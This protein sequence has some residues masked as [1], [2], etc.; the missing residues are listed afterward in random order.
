MSART[1]GPAVRPAGRPVVRV[2]DHAVVR[3]LQ[4]VYGLDVEAIRA[5]IL[6][7]DVAAMAARQGPGEYDVTGVR[8][9]CTVVTHRLT[10]IDRVTPGGPA[11]GAKPGHREAARQ[12]LVVTVLEPRC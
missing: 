11:P 5:E 6:P 8:A 7:P 10:V 1:T 12:R 9:G 3:Y 4:R 2:T